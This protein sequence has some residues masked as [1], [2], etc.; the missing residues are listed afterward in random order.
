MLA[1]TT[2]MRSIGTPAELERRRRLAVER[3]HEGYSTAEVA[4]FL[5]VTPRAVRLWVAAH[6]EQGALGL[7]ARPVDGRPRK[8]TPAQETVVLSWLTESP[9]TY[10]FHNELWTAKRVAEVIQWHWGITFN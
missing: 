3:F 2:V 7:A 8:L 5:G 1:Y 6:R 4:A 10:G 9:T